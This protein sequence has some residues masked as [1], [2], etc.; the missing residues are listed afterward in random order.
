MSSDEIGIIAAFVRRL[1]RLRDEIEA[2][3]NPG[4]QKWAEFQTA[5][6]ALKG[7][8]ASHPDD[9]DIS[10]CENVVEELISLSGKQFLMNVARD[11]TE[12]KRAE[13]ALREANER[14]I[15]E[16]DALK[17]KN[18]AL[19][20]VLNQIDN[21]KKEIGRHVRSNVDRIVMPI[22]SKLETRVG[23]DQKD[24]ITLLRSSLEEITFPF[25]NKL[26]AKFTSLTPREVQICN[27]IRNGLTSKEIA[28][29]LDT[30]ELTVR[31]QRKNIRRKLGI[32]RDK[33]NLNSFLQAM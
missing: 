23:P 28:S 17:E 3:E 7:L 20:E 2:S 29:A 15:A 4:I 30:S 11:I 24:Y 1:H 33:I 13:E 21:E 32:S 25:V 5:R 19:R 10:E 14:L 8:K 18:I 12:R 26:E 31:K 22:L 27:M 6:E 16:Q 9:A